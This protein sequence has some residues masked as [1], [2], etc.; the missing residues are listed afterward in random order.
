MKIIN[1]YSLKM[2]MSLEINQFNYRNNF[3][4]HIYSFII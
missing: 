1:E 2:I 4:I 3:E